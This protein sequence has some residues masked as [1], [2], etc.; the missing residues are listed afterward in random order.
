MS[1]KALLVNYRWCSGC[2]SCEVACQVKN[3]L[4]ADKFGIKVNQ[5]GPWEVASGKWQYRFFPV[6]TD[7]CNLCGD[8][9]SEGKLPSCVQHCQ[10]NCLQVL[11]AGEAARIAAE[12][13]KMLMMTL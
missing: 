3:D 10:A 5:V 9:I 11:D 2:H 4:P 13:P 12:N 7:Q 1:G 8:R 6:L